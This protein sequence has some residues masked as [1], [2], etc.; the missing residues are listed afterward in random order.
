MSGREDF[1]KRLREHPKYREALGRA[2]NAAE[3]KAISSVVEE[4]IGN[5][6]EVL[7]P[8]M[9]MAQ[10]DPTF[11]PKLAKAIKERQDVVS[12]QSQTPVSGSN[13]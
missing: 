6:G 1:I 8:A 9:D 4:F 2:R 11:A 13:S 5:F 3:R 10:A 12:Q 7:G